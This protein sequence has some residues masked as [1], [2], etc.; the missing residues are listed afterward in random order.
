MSLFR[1]YSPNEK[2]PLEGHAALM[3]TFGAWVGA[4]GVAHY[5][6]GRGLPNRYPAGDLLLMSVG[7]YKLSRLITKDRVTGF[8]RAPFTRFTGESDR[9][10]EVNEEPRG[11]GV[12]RAIGE[13]LVCP[14]CIGQWVGTAFLATYLRDP[15]LART[16]AVLFTIVSGSDLLQ[17]AW[18]AVD[19]R[20]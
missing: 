3:A 8:V 10:G 4:M 7:T 18:I 1:A 20:A 13:L 6:S 5:R 11:E 15:K 16:V 19:K 2:K 14:Y 9:P 12:Q 17:E